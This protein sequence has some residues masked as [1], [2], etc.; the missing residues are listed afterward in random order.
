MLRRSWLLVAGVLVFAAPAF[1]QET[2]SDEM[3]T[4]EVEP[5]VEPIEEPAAVEAEPVAE[6]AAAEAEAPAAEAEAAAAEAESTDDAEENLGDEVGGDMTPEQA[7]ADPAAYAAHLR[8]VIRAVKKSVLAK[9]EK[10]VMARQEAKIGRVHT[11]LVWVSL[12]GLLLLFLPLFLARRYPGRGGL[13]FRYSGLAALTAMVAINLFALVLLFLRTTQGELGAYTNPKLAIVEAA[14]D[15][16]DENADDLAA[17]GPLFIEP[18]IEKLT[19]DTEDDLPAVLLEKIAESPVAENVK[20]L[21]NDLGVFKTAA[22]FFEQ[23]S[24]VFALL[25]ILLTLM[26]VGLFLLAIRPTL[27]EIVQMPARAAQG[28]LGVGGRM[29]RLVLSR[30]GREFL[31]SA[32][33]VGVL[34]VSVMLASTLLYHAIKPAVELFIGYMVVAFAYILSKQGASGGLILFSLVMVIV[35]L[36]ANL[37]VILLANAA[38]LGKAQ[39]VFQQRFHQRVPLR[40]H[41]RFWAWGTA[42]LVWV[43]LFPL[44]FILAAEPVAGRLIEKL[45]GEGDDLQN[46]SWGLLMALVPALLVVGFAVL[47]W[48]ARGFRALGFLFRYKPALAAQAFEPAVALPAPVQAPPGYYP[49]P[50]YPVAPQQYPVTPQQYPVA[51]QPQP[52]PWPPQWPPRPQDP[53]DSGSGPAF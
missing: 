17:V 40:A 12:G 30:V 52:P 49:Q 44:L 4:I 22:A 18:T 21:R 46:V 31:A 14:F 6:A 39:K 20:Q 38:Y 13:L 45:M 37:L 36:A 47:F 3:P 34:L 15:T 42:S 32:C 19:S 8:E 7:E 16:L 10:K 1:A 51:P 43:Q 35:F 50:Q 41:R 27:V 25:P 29:V 5:I 24:W 9:M 11:V 23:M 33:V 28:Q 48:A 26:A 53:G 2:A